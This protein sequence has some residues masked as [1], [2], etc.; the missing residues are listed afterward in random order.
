MELIATVALKPGMIV[1]ED[2]TDY[3]GN[4]LVEEDTVLDKLIIQ[5]LLISSVKC[6]NIKKSNINKLDYYEKIGNGKAFKRF[7]TLYKTSFNSYKAIIDSFIYKKIIPDNEYILKIVDNIFLPFEKNVT[8]LMD[9]LKIQMDTYYD[10]LYTNSLNV[11]LLCKYTGKCFLLNHE[12]INLLTLCAFY[13]DIGKFKLQREL[14]QKETG[15]TKEERSLLMTIPVHSYNIIQNLPMDI[16]IKLAALMYKERFDGKGYPQ[17]LPAAR[18]NKFAGII[19]ILD[20]YE[21]ITSYKPGK[22]P[23]SPFAVIEMLEEKSGSHF[24]PAYS[25]PFMERIAEE[26]VGKECQLNNGL[27]YTIVMI[28]KDTITR[29]M[30]KREN[31]YTDLSK[32]STLKIIKLL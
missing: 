12:E 32:D 6:V 28:N 27:E 26:Y 9:M 4:L 30:L 31:T 15:L 24:N 7:E 25:L 5:K 21:K 20:Q 8:S 17:R 10:P 2:T 16:N 22:E 11:A 23:L 18:I 19:S 3:K 13:Y 14:V 1:A 29:P